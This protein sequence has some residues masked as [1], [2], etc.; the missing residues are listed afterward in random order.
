V[1][2]VVQGARSTRTPIRPVS[3]KPRPSG[4]VSIKRGEP[5]P[6]PRAARPASSLSHGSR[7]CRSMSCRRHARPAPTRRQDQTIPRRPRRLTRTSPRRETAARHPY[8]DQA[9][10]LSDGRLSAAARLLHTIRAV[11]LHDKRK[12]PRRCCRSDLAAA[13]HPL[14]AAPARVLV[15]A[16]SSSA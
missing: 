15:C 13:F 11:S 10:A 5:L 2:A 12:L 16:H 6:D 4:R 8:R 1:G 7:R 3:H 9:T 14:E